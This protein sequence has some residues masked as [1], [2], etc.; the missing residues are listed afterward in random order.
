[1]MMLDIIKVLK[2]AEENRL[3]IGTKEGIIITDKEGR[4]LFE[5]DSKTECFKQA[6]AWIDKNRTK[7]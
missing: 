7:F 4:L 6:C 2:F 5:S 1:M 3:S